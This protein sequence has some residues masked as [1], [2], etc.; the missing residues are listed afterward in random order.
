MPRAPIACTVQL[1]RAEPVSVAGTIA[2]LRC[3]P[4]VPAGDRHL[5]VASNSAGSVDPAAAELGRAHGVMVINGGCPLMFAPTSDGPHR[6]L[7]HVCTWTG[8]VPRRV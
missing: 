3:E 4:L 1:S 7:K 2:A 5:D 8:K 6:F